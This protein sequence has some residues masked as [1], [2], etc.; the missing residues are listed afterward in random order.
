MPVTEQQYLTLALEDPE[1]H[2][3][4]FCGEPRQKPTKTAEHG[5]IMAHLAVL[6]GPQLDREVFRVRVSGSLLHPGFLCRAR[7]AVPRTSGSRSGAGC[8]HRRVAARG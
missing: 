1:G 5:D 6:I 4:L 7:A 3:E 2:W 8:L